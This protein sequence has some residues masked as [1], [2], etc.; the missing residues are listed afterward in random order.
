MLGLTD[1]ELRTLF[2]ESLK[3]NSASNAAEESRP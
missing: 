2:D 3:N 1:D